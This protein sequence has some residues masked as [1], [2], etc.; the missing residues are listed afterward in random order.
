MRHCHTKAATDTKTT[1]CITMVEAH[2][3]PRP[4]RWNLHPTRCTAHTKQAPHTAWYVTNLHCDLRVSRLGQ[5]EA[6]LWWYVSNHSHLTA[7]QLQSTYAASLKQPAAS[8]SDAPTPPRARPE[9]TASPARKHH[10]HDKRSHSRHSSHRHSTS[11]N[12]KRGRDESARA[13][14]RSRSVD[15]RRT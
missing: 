7:A 1:A 5:V 12:H 6:A 2:R 14:S 15:V 8:A 10:R 9:A 11:R 4:F 13:S 3:K